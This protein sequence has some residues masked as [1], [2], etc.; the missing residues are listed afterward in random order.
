MSTDQNNTPP[1]QTIAII[2]ARRGSKGLPDKNI[3]PLC[4]K[5][6]LAYSIEVALKVP[7]ISTVLV[8]TEDEEIA[9]MARHYGAQVPFLR[10]A[11]L[12][13]DHSCI[14]DAVD[15]VITT[16]AA[17]GEVY[18]RVV[19]LFPTHPFRSEDLIRSLVDKMADHSSVYT[20]KRIDLGG[21]GALLPMPGQ[22]LRPI[23]KPEWCN[24]QI[25]PRPFYRRY[26]TF[27]GASDALGQTPYIHVLDNPV[28]LID[29]DYLEDFNLAEM[30]IKEGLYCFM[31]GGPCTS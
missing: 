15:H 17:R 30:V 9:E 16:L 8:S 27:L 29:I 28:E 7:C 14:G 1:P 23:Q 24:G 25:R 22:R 31:R 20:V 6:L 11:H 4:G 3:R 5:P 21:G 2:P 18:R 13:Q 26:G 10:P 12:A 19:T